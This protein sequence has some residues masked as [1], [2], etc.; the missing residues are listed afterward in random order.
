MGNVKKIYLI[1]I[2]FFNIKTTQ[3]QVVKLTERDSIILV[4]KEELH[5]GGLIFYKDEYSLTLFNRDNAHY[6]KKNGYEHKTLPD[7]RRYCEK[8]KKEYY[9][10]FIKKY[11]IFP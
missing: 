1:T 5:E 3:S 10:F 4:K 2:F 8:C 6:N 7:G 9:V 11:I